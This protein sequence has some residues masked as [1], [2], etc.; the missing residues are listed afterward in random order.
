MAPRQELLLV[1]L[2]CGVVACAT[3]SRPITDPASGFPPAT[4]FAPAP[5]PQFDPALHSVLWSDDFESYTSD[6]ALHQAYVT[7]NEQ[8]IHIE[9]AA[10]LGASQAERFDWFASTTCND[11]SVTCGHSVARPKR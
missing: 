11:D 8:F 1:V 4:T 2:I 6:S 7:L 9:S 5:E 3:D 10:G